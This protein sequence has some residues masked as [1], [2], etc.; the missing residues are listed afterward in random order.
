MAA[1]L[2]G[3]EHRSRRTSTKIKVKA[4]MMLRPTVSRPV[5]LGIKHP[6]GAS[7]QIFI[8]VRQYEGGRMGLSLAR[9][10]VSSNKSFATMY[11][12]HFML[13]NLFIYNIYS[14]KIKVKV[15]LTLR[16]TVSQPVRLG[17][18]PHLGLMT[19][20]LLLF[21]NYGLVLGGRPL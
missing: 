5:C 1:S 11:N 7:V 19:R 4:K 18:E 2:R 12:L 8:T 6:S 10:T 17:V 13:L 14:T 16:L 21:D 3:R 20:Y 9:D 15:K